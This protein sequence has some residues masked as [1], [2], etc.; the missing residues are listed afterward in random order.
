MSSPT[1]RDLEQRAKALGARARVVRSVS[2]IQLAVAAAKPHCVLAVATH[3]A[4]TLAQS[5]PLP[6][7]DIHTT[8]AQIDEH[9]SP[10]NVVLD[11]G[12]PSTPTISRTDVDTLR[13]MSPPISQGNLHNLLVQLDEPPSGVQMGRYRLPREGFGVE[14]PDPPLPPSAPRGPPAGLINS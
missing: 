1:A 8:L 12:S 3:R 7:N 11:L 9:S 2:S 6:A 14:E 5:S 4:L 10:K 13:T